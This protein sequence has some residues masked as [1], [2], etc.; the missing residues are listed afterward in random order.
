MPAN[1]I[2]PRHKVH[3]SCWPTAEQQLLLR[4][5]LLEGEAAANAWQQWT[6]RVDIEAIDAGTYRLLPLLHKNLERLGL[7]DKNSSKLKG[8]H[9]LTWCRNRLLFHHVQAPLKALNEAGV[10]VML[11]KGA[12]LIDDFYK[13]RGARPMGDFDILVPT[14][15]AT[16]AIGVL[17]S[18][19]WRPL[20]RSL[21]SFSAN[22]F[23]IMHADA[24]VND[25]GYEIDLHWHLLYE[26]CWPEAD[27]D[28]WQ[29]TGA[30]EFEG[31]TVQTLA[32]GD[33]LLHVCTHG[34]RWNRVPALRWIAD[35]KLI[36]DAARPQIDW[37]RFI[38]LA[39]D[40][41]L[42]LV[43]HGS[44]GYLDCHL[45]GNIPRDVL[46]ALA[47][48]PVSRPAQ[49]DFQTRT[50]PAYLRWYHQLRYPW[51]IHTDAL[52]PRPLG[53]LIYLQHFYGLPHAWLVPAHIVKRIFQMARDRLR[54][55][56]KR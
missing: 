2:L 36:L 46:Q 21:E 24:F 3:H 15:Q 22:Y 25:D 47:S 37:N 48:S 6:A 44:L 17:Q 34:V 1:S 19:G 50:T 35:A 8:V 31:A 32:P 53:L 29:M 5:C 56:G 16:C 13:D 43:V 40:R 52:Q 11:L 26:C 14:S 7:Q 28:F 55:R 9:R 33:L 10:P 45:E 49:L 38:R 18:A 42:T 39:R 4:A 23:S 51:L 20:R 30:R 12:A 41:E 27:Q 54:R